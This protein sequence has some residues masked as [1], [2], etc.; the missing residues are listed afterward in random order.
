MRSSSAV[1]IILIVTGAVGRLVIP[2]GTV[3]TTEPIG[4]GETRGGLIDPPG[5]VPTVEP[6][7][8]VGVNGGLIDPPGTVPT[9][10]PIGLVGTVEGLGGMIV[11]EG[12]GL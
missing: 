1:G 3:P 10:E 6:I 5:T 4:L 11:L 8:L 7:G 2:P 9:T 12:S